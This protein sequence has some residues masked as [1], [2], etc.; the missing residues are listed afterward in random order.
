MESYP[1]Q[2]ASDYG[3]AVGSN[4]PSRVGD[5]NDELQQQEDQHDEQQ[6]EIDSEDTWAVVGSFFEGKGLVSQQ[7]ESFNDFASYKLQ[8][9]IDAHPPIEIRCK[10]RF[11]SLC[12]RTFAWAVDPFDSC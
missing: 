10:S 11:F 4:S 6:Q 7:V 5:E 3:L 9:I 12:R 1:S 2:G 8:E